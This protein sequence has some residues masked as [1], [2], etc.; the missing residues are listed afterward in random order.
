MEHR[1]TSAD[2]DILTSLF[3]DI[4]QTQA[5]APENRS[6]KLEADIRLDRSIQEIRLE[7]AEQYE[8]TD[9]DL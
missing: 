8:R 4:N 3:G 5:C 7:Q 1:S 9:Y 6:W 2:K